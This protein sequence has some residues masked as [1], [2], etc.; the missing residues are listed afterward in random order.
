[1]I[2]RVKSDMD[3]I[4]RQ[5]TEAE[6]TIDQSNSSSAALKNIVPAFIFVSISVILLCITT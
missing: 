2:A 3:K 1:M 4:E 5:L 6:N